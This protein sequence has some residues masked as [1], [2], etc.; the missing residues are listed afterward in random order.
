M[1]LYY[2]PGAC[3]LSPHIALREAGLAFTLVK[4]DLRTHRLEDGS[5]FYAVNAKG[6]VPMLELDDG[7]RLTEGPAIV[8]YI[9]DLVPEKTL[10][11]PAGSFARYRLQEALNFI[12]SEIHKAYVP[13]FVPG[14]SAETRD[15]YRQR[16][17]RA[18]ELADRRLAAA[19]YLMGETF[20]VADPYLFTT[21]TWAPHAKVDLAGLDALAAFQT[22]MGQR[23]AV[24]AALAAEGLA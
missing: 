14:F 8:Q 5:D 12:S 4:A 21:V 22:R 24:Q 10:A 6:Y 20:G 17:R 16:V 3:S 2:T 7:E 18:Y 11:P 19:P 15:L 1:K 23:P 9:A 13:L